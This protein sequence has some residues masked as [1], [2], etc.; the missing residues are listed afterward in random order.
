MRIDD[1]IAHP[2]QLTLQNKKLERCIALGVHAAAFT[3]WAIEEDFHGKRHDWKTTEDGKGHGPF[4]AW[5]QSMSVHIA[6][7]TTEHNKWTLADKLSREAHRGMFF[8]RDRHKGGKSNP[9]ACTSIICDHC[10]AKLYIGHSGLPA[11]GGKKA[12]SRVIQGV[13]HQIV[14][15]LFTATQIVED[16][17]KERTA[18]TV[19]RHNRGS[20]VQQN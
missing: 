16:R 12:D 11:K 18:C 9:N 13:S 4:I 15:S 3:G 6:N 1:P 10:G 5:L 8:T 7:H 14:D 19:E 17:L 2:I 20:V